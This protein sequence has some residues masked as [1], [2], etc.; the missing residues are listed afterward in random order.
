MLLTIPGHPIVQDQ[1]EATLT[2][3]F[4]SFSSTSTAFKEDSFFS[5]VWYR[6]SPGENQLT[7]KI[8]FDKL[9]EKAINDISSFASLYYSEAKSEEKEAFQQ[10]LSTHC[11]G[12]ATIYTGLTLSWSEN[13][14]SESFIYLAK[15]GKVEADHFVEQGMLTKLLS[16]ILEGI[17]SFS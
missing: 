11:L 2:S 4:S 17:S 8:S 14:S 3:L 12:Y 10:F 15:D 1:Y 5:N 16:Q 7:R 13:S 6:F 9:M